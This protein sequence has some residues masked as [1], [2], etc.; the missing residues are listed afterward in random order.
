MSIKR[1]L[2]LSSAIFLLNG[3]ITITTGDF[4]SH[5]PEAT[6]PKMFVKD[7]LS[8]D[9]MIQDSVDCQDDAT[10]RATNH[11]NYTSSVGFTPEQVAIYDACMIRKGYKEVD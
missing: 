2:I 1:L 8:Q 9:Q 4:M 3:C 10:A 6:E 5:D 11:G 7:G